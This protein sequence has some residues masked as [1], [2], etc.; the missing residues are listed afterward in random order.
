MPNACKIYHA[1]TNSAMDFT[2]KRPFLIPQSSAIKLSVASMLATN[3]LIHSPSLLR[4]SPPV[5][6]RFELDLTAPSLRMK[7]PMSGGCHLTH[8]TSQV[9]SLLLWKAL[10]VSLASFFAPLETRLGESITG[11]KMFFFRFFQVNHKVKEN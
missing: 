1:L 4:V 2:K 6:A 11:W 9:L 7:Q 8:R 5:E 3:P 10:L